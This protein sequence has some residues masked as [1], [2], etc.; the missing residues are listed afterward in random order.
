MHGCITR[1]GSVSQCLRDIWNDTKRLR[2]HSFITADGMVTMNYIWL[3]SSFSNF[4]RERVRFLISFHVL[5]PNYE[6]LSSFGIVMLACGSISRNLFKATSFT[7]WQIIQCCGT[8]ALASRRWQQYP[9]TSCY[10]V[11]TTSF[12]GQWKT[13]FTLTT[14]RA[15]YWYHAYNYIQF[16]YWSK[17]WGHL[18]QR[19]SS[20]HA[21][22][23]KPSKFKLIP[24]PGQIFPNFWLKLSISN[25][26]AVKVIPHSIS[27]FCSSCGISDA[28]YHSGLRWNIFNL[29]VLRSW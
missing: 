13:A 7:K 5:L 20:P 29:R 3:P 14:D 8:G 19:W 1:S 15:G 28:E 21:S 27:H 16:A 4:L 17:T 11:L 24:F 18:P 9:Q 25:Y 6:S 23:W 10:Y 22:I 2:L 26:M 12:S